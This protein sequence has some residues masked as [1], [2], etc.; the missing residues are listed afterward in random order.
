MRVLLVDFNPFMPPVTPISLGNIGAV[1]KALGHEVE[2]LS[3]GSN[4]RF[5]PNALLAFLEEF[6]PRLIGFS[7][8]QR[9]MFQTRA[10]AKMAKETLADVSVVLGGPQA[11]F[12]PAVA[13]ASMPEVDH[14]SR[15]EGELTIKAIVQA[16]EGGREDQP[17]PGVT[18]RITPTYFHSGPSPKPLANLDSYPSPWLTGVLDPAMLEE[19]IM[20]TS[21]GCYN[22]CC[23]CHTPAAFAGK[24]SA[25]SVD[26]V[27]EDIAWVT[28]AGT[29]RLWF[30]DP[31]FS[32]SNQRVIDILEGVIRRNLKV[33]MWVET[34]ADMLHPELIALMKRAGVHSIAMGL[35]SASPN[36]YPG[37]NKGLE[38]ELIARATSMAQGAELEVEL[39]S[40]Y[41]LP[42]ET[43]E[44]ALQTLQFVKDCGVP[45]RGNTNAQQMQLYF[46]SEVHSNLQKFGVRP[47]RK[48]YPSYLAIG[49]EFETRWMSREEIK[50][51]K[52]AWRAESL[53]GGK[54]VVS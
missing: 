50:K 4:S 31:N 52:A 27:L 42:G 3:L 22:N 15:G 41:A 46:G 12:L 29:G 33:S 16:I 49:T 10:I 40:Q 38:P 24:I 2:I 48:K 35:E 51:V 54:R 17:I 13:L 14:L 18:T 53:D 23:F 34:R 25:Q 21:R 45:I 32:F 6:S 43:L 20:L 5:S 30:A 39:F 8:Y 26:R 1:L 36:V 7:A 28:R 44:D 47:L 19:S 37:L 11:T 9:N